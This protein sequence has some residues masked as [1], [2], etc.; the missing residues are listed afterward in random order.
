M[1]MKKHEGNLVLVA[2]VAFDGKQLCREK[3]LIEWFKKNIKKCIN[4]TD[5][6]KLKK[7]LEI[8]AQDGG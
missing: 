4:Y 8:Y 5:L 2:M 6:G 3:E 7:H 1:L